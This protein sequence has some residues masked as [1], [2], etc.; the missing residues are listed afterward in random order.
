MYIG[1]INGDDPNSYKVQKLDAE[2]IIKV[3]KVPFDENLMKNVSEIAKENDYIIESKLWSIC[4]GLW[5][6]KFLK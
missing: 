2:E 6:S 5:M 1:M 3:I 4:L